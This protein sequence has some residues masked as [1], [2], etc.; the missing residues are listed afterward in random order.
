[1]CCKIDLDF[2]IQDPICIIHWEDKKDKKTTFVVH[3]LKSL[4]E[5]S[6]LD[7]FSCVSDSNTLESKQFEPEFQG[8][9]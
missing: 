5:H 7:N 4:L 1:M 9:G 6:Y 3:G 2:K 8:Q